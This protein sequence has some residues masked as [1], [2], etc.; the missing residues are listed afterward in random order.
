[1]YVS[2]ETIEHILFAPGVIESEEDARGN[3]DKLLPPIV[4]L[5]D[6]E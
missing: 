5:P 1:M 2:R 4:S 6:S 3:R